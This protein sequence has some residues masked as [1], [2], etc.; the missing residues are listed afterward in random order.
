MRNAGVLLLAA[1]VLA[2]AGSGAAS[3]GSP[4]LQQLIGQKLVVRME[5]KAPSA[6]LLA[7]ARA[8]Q[9]GGVIVH[10]DNLSTASALRADREPAPAGRR[11]GRAAAAPDRDRPG[12]RLGQDGLVDPAHPLAAPDGKAPLGP[13]RARPG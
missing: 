13:D 5:G 2:A 7:R 10:G 6:S 11:G 4:T 1:A 8:G 12:G 3:S 9:I